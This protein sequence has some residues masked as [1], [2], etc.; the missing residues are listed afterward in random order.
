[1]LRGTAE[2]EFCDVIM[3]FCRWGP[4][5]F[6][7]F[8]LSCTC[9]MLSLGKITWIIPY[10]DETRKVYSGSSREKLPEELMELV[11]VMA[12]NVHEV[13][14]QSRLSEGWTYGARRDDE[15]KTHPCLVPYEELPEIEKD[16]D[17]NTAIG[18]LK[19]IQALGF[20]IVKK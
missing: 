10:D 5:V 7:M 2:E 6:C 14:S 13:W 20:D 1:M 11:E 15:K 17:R 16:Y 4:K 8:I 19:L 12:K 3:W 9:L 18:T